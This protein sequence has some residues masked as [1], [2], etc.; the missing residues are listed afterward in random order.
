MLLKA[1]LPLSFLTP[2]LEEFL[3]C[4]LGRPFPPPEANSVVWPLVIS[5]SPTLSLL[6]D[7]KNQVLGRKKIKRPSSQE[8]YLFIFV[9]PR[10]QNDWALP[11][12]PNA[13]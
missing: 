11:P 9:F 6:L 4:V 1:L 3:L 5:H 8:L 7:F 13:Q 12:A 2:Q 10:A